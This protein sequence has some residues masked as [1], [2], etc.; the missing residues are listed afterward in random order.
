M[1]FLISSNSGLTI[2]AFAVLCH[3]M[4]A[5]VVF[6][7]DCCRHNSQV[8]WRVLPLGTRMQSHSVNFGEEMSGRMLTC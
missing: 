6:E 7:P 5:S 8:Q 4:I 3:A 2:C 1:N